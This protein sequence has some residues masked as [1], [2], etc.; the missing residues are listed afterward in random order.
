MNTNLLLL[1][2]IGFAVLTVIFLYLLLKELRTGINKTGWEPS[3]QKRYFNTILAAIVGWLVVVSIWSGS[4]MMAD[5][6]LFPL[7]FAPVIVIPLITILV[8]T[9]SRNLSE[10]LMNIPAANIIRLQVFRFFV[11]LLLWALFVASVLPEQMTFEGR[12]LDILSG[13]TAPFIAWLVSRHKISKA[14]LI[15]WN[16]ACLGLLINI[17]TVAILSTP[18]P[19][20]VFMNEPSNTIVAYFPVSWLPAFLVPL[21]YTLHFLSLRQLSRQTTAGT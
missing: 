3:K 9:F 19:I 1:A 17:V 6:S 4:G 14:G 21:A 5:F 2:K 16:F 12:N 20:R 10:V 11:E 8:W 13:V 18:S 7:N 15:L